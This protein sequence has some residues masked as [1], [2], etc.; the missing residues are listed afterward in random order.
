MREQL[1]EADRMDG[2]DAAAQ[3]TRLLSLLQHRVLQVIRIFCDDIA[4]DL[5][6]KMVHLFFIGTNA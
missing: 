6:D 3:D 1:P 4:G 5:P 2:K